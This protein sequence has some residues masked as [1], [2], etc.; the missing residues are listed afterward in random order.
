MKG[1]IIAIFLSILF[2]DC[3]KIESDIKTLKVNKTKIG[4]TLN[5]KTISKALE[6]ET[7]LQS[8]D[9]VGWKEFP[10]KPKVDFRIAHTDSVMFLKFYVNE[11]HILAKRSSTNSAT[12]KDSCV[13]FFIDPIGDGNYYNFEFNCIGT[14]HLAYGL[15]GYQRT[16]IPIDLISDQIKVWSTLGNKTFEEKSGNF[17]WEMVILIPSTIFINNVNFSFSKLIANANFYKCGDETQKPHYLSWSPVKTSKPDFH[18]P[19]YFVKFIF[20]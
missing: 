1:F 12:H 7:N 18:S 9:L 16:F 13:E 15:N 3:N 2:T 10:Y 8:I 17:Y 14:T 5:F 20:Q 4:E 11:N 19:E 6:K